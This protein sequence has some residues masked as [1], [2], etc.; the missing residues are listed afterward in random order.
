MFLHARG[1]I[2]FIMVDPLSKYNRGY[3]DWECDNYLVM[4]WLWNN[5]ETLVSVNFMFLYTTK[6]LWDAAE[7]TYSLEKKI[8]GVYKLYVFLLQQ[9]DQSLGEY[10]GVFQ[11]MLDELDGYHSLT[12]DLKLS[13]KQCEDLLVSKLFVGLNLNLH[14]IC[15]QILCG[16]GGIPFLSNVYA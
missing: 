9:G 12:N 15:N 6:E 3:E 1:K 4:R 10:Y 16:V 14:T 11:E 7:E 13:K 8:C 5:M 2:N